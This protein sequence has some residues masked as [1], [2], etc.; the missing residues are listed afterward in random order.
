M[1]LEYEKYPANVTMSHCVHAHIAQPS[2]INRS[3]IAGR[4]NRDF[5]KW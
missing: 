2:R 1:I 4:I 5:L 3:R